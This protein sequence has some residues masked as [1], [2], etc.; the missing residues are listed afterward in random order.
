M[1]RSF[2]YTHLGS[3]GF[4]LRLACGKPQVISVCNIS[5]VSGF[6]SAGGEPEECR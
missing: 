4:S 2:T 5:S 1:V 3:L 6:V